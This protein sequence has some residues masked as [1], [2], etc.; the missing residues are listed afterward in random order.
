MQVKHLLLIAILGLTAACSS[1]KEVIDEN[2]SEAE[3][4]QQAQADLDNSSYTSAVNKLKAL[5]SRYPFGRYADQAQLELIYANYKNAEPEAAK[6]AAERFIRLH[7]QHP[8][9]DYAYYLKGLTSFDQDRGLLARF[10]PLDM[11]KRDPGAARDSY[12]EFAQLTS[13]FPNSRYAPDAKQRMIYLRNLLAAYEIHV[14]HYYLTRQAYVASANRG[15]YV[16][17]N[18]QETPSVAD[19][20]AVMVE[21]YQ[22]LHLDKLAD[23][24]LEVLKDNYPNHPSLV[25]GQ[26]VP[27]VSESDNRSWLSKATLGLIE[28]STPLPPG[29]TRANQDVQKQFQDAKD[30]IPAELKPKDS[31]GNVIEEPESEDTS[32]SWFSYMTFGL[33][34]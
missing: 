18:F 2:L 33:F 32:R 19:G 17:E 16:V 27:Q 6:S 23:T 7:P 9:V 12:N 15:R 4:Y 31:D 5:E 34:D 3:L 24:S 13:R 14:A 11:T 25:D 10:L 29:E 30:A 28:S 26:F 8:N 21:S 1:N 20:L 22:R